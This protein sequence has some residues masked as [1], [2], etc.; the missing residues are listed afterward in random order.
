MHVESKRNSSCC[1]EVENNKSIAKKST[2]LWPKTCWSDGHKGTTLLC[3][4]QS[5]VIWSINAEGRHNQ[6]FKEQLLIITNCKIM[7]QLQSGEDR[8]R[9]K[10]RQRTHQNLSKQP[11]HQ[12]P[13]PRPST[14]VMID[15][16]ATITTIYNIFGIV[17]H[18]FS[19][20]GKDK[21]HLFKSHQWW[22][23][24]QL[25]PRPQR[26]NRFKMDS[27]GRRRELHP[28]YQPFLKWQ[29]CCCFPK[30][31]ITVQNHQKAKYLRSIDCLDGDIW[32]FHWCS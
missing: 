13:Q 28:Q 22:S 5:Y 6:V 11:Q 21:G 14:G 27:W 8:E 9:A 2:Y 1:R 31:T 7:P 3:C 30:R 15:K 17:K 25:V 26:W 29:Q 4:I 24:G 16:C 19:N 20:G 10:S 18:C 23:R 12:A 32:S